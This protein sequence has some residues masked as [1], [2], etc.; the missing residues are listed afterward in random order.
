M[1]HIATVKLDVKDL[2]ALAEA[3]GRCGL[4]LARDQ[5][6]YRWYRRRPKGCDHA[7]RIPEGPQKSRDAYEIGVVKRDDG[8]YEL[9]WDPFAGGFGLVERAGRN[10]DALKQA[11][12]TV[13][14]KKQLQRQAQGFRVQEQR[15]PNGVIR[16]LATR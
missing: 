11:Y 3:A 16:L 1:S 6:T 4:E 8:T 14:A 9:K 5:K 15:L 13:V 7:I 10:C 12:A 2:D